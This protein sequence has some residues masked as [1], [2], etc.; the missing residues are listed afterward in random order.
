M[1]NAKSIIRESVQWGKQTFFFGRSLEKPEGLKNLDKPIRKQHEHNKV[2]TKA[3]SD[4][5]L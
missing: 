5:K 2:L 1:L 4:V 3:D